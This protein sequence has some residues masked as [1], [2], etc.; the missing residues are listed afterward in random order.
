M[1][2]QILNGLMGILTFYLVVTGGGGQA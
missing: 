1:K 2:H